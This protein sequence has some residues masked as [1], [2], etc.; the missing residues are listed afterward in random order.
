MLLTGGLVFDGNTIRSGLGVLIAGEAIAAVEPVAAFAGYGGPIVDTAG[1]TVLPGLIDAHVHV[2]LPPGVDAFQK[3]A[4]WGPADFMVQGVASSQRS[5]RR[6]PLVRRACRPSQTRRLRAAA[7]PGRRVRAP[8]NAAQL[9]F[10]RAK[11]ALH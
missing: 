10:V 4:G 2:L 5:A 9:F 8:C 6:R 7:A 1:G 3:I 11:K